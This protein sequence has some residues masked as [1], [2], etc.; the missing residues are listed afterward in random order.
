MHIYKIFVN[1]EEVYSVTNFDAYEYENA[2]GKFL[3]F[4]NILQL[5]DSKFELYIFSISVN[6][7]SIIEHFS[8]NWSF[9]KPQL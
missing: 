4:Y 8:S 2:S 6:D 9:Q 3:K 7:S 1:D 5:F